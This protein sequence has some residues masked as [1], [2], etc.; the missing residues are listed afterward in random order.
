M[1]SIGIA[2]M[3]GIVLACAYFRGTKT[4]SHYCMTKKFTH[5][6]KKS[7]CVTRK[8]YMHDQKVYVHLMRK[9]PNDVK[10]KVSEYFRLISRKRSWQVNHCYYACPASSFR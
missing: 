4:W 2:G 8:G 3:V 10:T 7:T 6:P 1:H 9:F 5:V